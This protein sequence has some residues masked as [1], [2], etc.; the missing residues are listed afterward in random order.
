M[1]YSISGHSRRQWDRSTSLLTS[2]TTICRP[3]SRTHPASAHGHHSVRRWLNCINLS[4]PN[5]GSESWVINCNTNRLLEVWYTWQAKLTYLHAVDRWLN[6]P[7]CRTSSVWL[8]LLKM[9]CVSSGR[10]ICWTAEMCP[11]GWK[12]GH[13]FWNFRVVEMD[14]N[15]MSWTRLF[16]FLFCYRWSIKGYNLSS[17]II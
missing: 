5:W 16:L 14:T 8:R 4:G 17:D 12:T 2:G 11:K 6:L 3:W 13:K 1:L 15:R 10:H 7:G 9:S